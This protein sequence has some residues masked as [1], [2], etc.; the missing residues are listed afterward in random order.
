MISIAAAADKAEKPPFEHEMM[1]VANGCFVE[2]VVFLDHWQDTFGGDAWARMLQWGAKEDEEVVAGH[3]VAICQAK[4]KLWCWDINFGWAPLA[5][6]ATQRENPALVAVPVV[7]K[8]PKI[9]VQFPLYRQEYAQPPA[10][11]PPVAQLSSENMSIRDA[12][13]VAERLAKHR[14]VNVV[15]FPVAGPGGQTRESAAVIFNFHGRICVYVPEQGTT[16][17]RARGGV[18]NLVLAQQILRR[19]VPGSGLVKKL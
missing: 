17:T 11:K 18:E 5:V 8:Y 1:G 2:S 14:P 19:I 3:A 16:P 6:A 9:A 7:A 13:L 10:E 15:R 12:T 4:G